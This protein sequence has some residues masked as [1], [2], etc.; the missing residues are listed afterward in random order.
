[1]TLASQWKSQFDDSEETDDELAGEHLQS[2]EHLP[3]LARL[4]VAMLQQQMYGYGSAPPSPVLFQA[5]AMSPSPPEHNQQQQPDSVQCRSPS[6]GQQMYQAFCAAVTL[7]RRT[8]RPTAERVPSNQVAEAAQQQDPLVKGSALD[9]LDVE[10][11]DGVHM[12][13][14]R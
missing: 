9:G 8:V 14:Y 10:G 4:G 3:A 6:G 2:P 13:T 7:P 5:P 1:M 11:A 12:P